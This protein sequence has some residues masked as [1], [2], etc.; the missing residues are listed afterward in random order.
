MGQLV[1]DIV[2]E[3]AAG[4]AV[5]AILGLVAI[6][7]GLPYIRRRRRGLLRFFGL[8]KDNQRFL[9]YFSTLFVRTNGAADFRGRRRSF[10]G[11][12]VPATELTT[13]QPISQ[14]FANPLLLSLPASVRSWLGEKVHWT[15]RQIMP[16]FSF[17]PPST[18]RVEPT[19][20]ITIGSRYY[21][22]AGDLY[23]ETG[24]PFLKMEQVGQ[25]MVIRVRKGQRRG[26]EFTQRPGHR[27]DLAIVE[28][29]HDGAHKTSV[30]IAAGLGE[31]GTLGAVH[32]LVNNW[33]Q[34][35]K[36]F[37]SEPFAICLR[38]ENIGDDPFAFEKPVEEARLQ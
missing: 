7:L 30:F 1:I 17:S 34:L 3:I 14:L 22:S 23:A 13:A 18:N 21:N 31:V 4:L 8:T 5:A 6:V 9:V 33:K 28:K 19:N 32:Y 24:D 35:H 2:G 38:F 25:G 15:F 20:M 11:P 10:Q 12:A 36:D 27:D 16:E 26:T 29:L 37:G